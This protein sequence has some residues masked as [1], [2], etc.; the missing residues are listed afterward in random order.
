MIKRPHDQKVAGRPGD[1][2]THRS[3][4]SDPSQPGSTAPATR[5]PPKPRCQRHSCQPTAGSPA[6]PW[7]A[8]FWCAWLQMEDEPHPIMGVM[9][10]ILQPNR[11]PGRLSDDPVFEDV[12]SAGTRNSHLPK[13]LRRVSG[14]GVF[15]PPEGARAEVS[16][17]HCQ[18]LTAPGGARH[19]PAGLF[20]SGSAGLGNN[21]RTSQHAASA[22]PWRPRRPTPARAR[23]SDCAAP[24]A[25]PSFLPPTS[26]PGT[27]RSGQR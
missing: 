5:P 24:P 13:G 12:A 6:V 26:K 1:P 4:Y 25:G 16:T 9:N 23:R 2:A 7:R 17:A 22:L 18:H 3:R 10:L 8:W 15:A 19:R 11:L 20:A 21:R 27:Y 14:A